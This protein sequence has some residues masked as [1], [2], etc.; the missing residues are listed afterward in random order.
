MTL[1]IVWLVSN[2]AYLWLTSRLTSNAKAMHDPI[3]SSIAVLAGLVVINAGFLV[4]A[5]AT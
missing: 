2:C 5:L 3:G 1:F 4:Y